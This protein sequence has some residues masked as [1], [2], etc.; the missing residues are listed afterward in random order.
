[1]TYTL[2]IDTETTGLPKM[3]EKRT[4]Y[5]YTES[6]KYDISRLLELGYVLYENKKEIKKYEKLV[7]VNFLIHNSDIHGITNADT[8][9]NGV[10]IHDILNNLFND[11]KDIDV[12]IV[13]HNIKFDINIL[14]SEAH[15]YGHN[16]L[17]NKINSCEQKCTCQMAKEKLRLN[18]YIKLVTLYKKLFHKKII[19]EHRALSDVYLCSEC[20]FQLL[21]I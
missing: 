15:R 11:I 13:A 9:V 18:Y 6:D 16:D 10:C 14:L 5:D 12:T 17:I 3:T 7:N 2:V 8:I 4:Y 21:E 20:Y 1:M 19:Q